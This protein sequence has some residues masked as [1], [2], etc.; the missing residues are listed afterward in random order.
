[1]R[2]ER[3]I[4]TDNLV[5]AHATLRESGVPE[6]MARL[7]EVEPDLFGFITASINCVAGRLSLV[8]TPNAAVRETAE[9]MLELVLTCLIAER[10]LNRTLE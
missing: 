8:E 4:T 10:Q 5:E 9:E 7:F 2:A 1:M 6:A 3:T